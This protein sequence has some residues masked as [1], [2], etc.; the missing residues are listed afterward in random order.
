MYFVVRKFQ[1]GSRNLMKNL[2]NFLLLL[3]VL[4]VLFTAIFYYLSKVPVIGNVI[5]LLSKFLNPFK[6]RVEVKIIGSVLYDIQQMGFL[7]LAT[8]LMED[9]IK[10]RDYEYELDTILDGKYAVDGIYIYRAKVS[11]GVDLFKIEQD[12]VIIDETQTR[13][14]IYLPPIELLEGR[15]NVERLE[16]FE[17]NFKSKIFGRFEIGAK[18]TWIPLEIKERV[19]SFCDRKAEELLTREIEDY[20]R[21]KNKYEE[22][23][24]RAEKYITTLLLPY[25]AKGYSVNVLW[26]E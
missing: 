18:D 8:V 9:V 12:D 14:T 26:K 13:I 24:T 6:H 7:R 19:Y 10:T 21:N 11:Y 5:S 17:E 4:V 1:G 15:I 3:I 16:T 25:T 22:M 20:M 23:K 2:W